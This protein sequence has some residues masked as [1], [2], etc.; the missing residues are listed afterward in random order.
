MGKQQML[1]GKQQSLYKAG[2]TDALVKAVALLGSQAE[3]ARKIGK[4][5]AH[6]WNWLH[7]DHR[8][9]ADMA[10]RIEE[11]TAG[12]VTRHELRPDLYP[13]QGA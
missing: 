4:K 6:I 7:R 13:E 9:P 12:R 3:L 2:M 11:A 1:T 8:V 5:Q 10:M